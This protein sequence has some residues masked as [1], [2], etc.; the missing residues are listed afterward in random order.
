M[1]GMDPLLAGLRGGDKDVNFPA[2]FPSREMI[3]FDNLVAL[4]IPFLHFERALIIALSLTKES[5]LAQYASSLTCLPLLP[6]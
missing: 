1:G 5:I 4:R 3:A 6:G 2:T